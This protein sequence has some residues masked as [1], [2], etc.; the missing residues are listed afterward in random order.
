M[1]FRIFAVLRALEHP[2]RQVEPGRAILAF[3]ITIRREIKYRT[4]AASM[5]QDMRHHLI[6]FR[7]ATTA[8]LIGRAATISDARYNQSMLDEGNPVLVSSK[9]CDRTN[10]A[11]SE[12][13]AICVARVFAFESLR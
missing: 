11:G 8:P 1:I 2:D 7:V 9:P 12:Q 13:E 3:V 5:S 6:D 4:V 10:R